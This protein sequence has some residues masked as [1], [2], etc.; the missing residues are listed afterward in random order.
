MRIEVH[1]H[2]ILRDCLPR[3]AKG[4]QATVEVP[5]GATIADLVR[6]MAIDKRLGYDAEDLVTGASWQVM[7]SGKIESDLAREL[8]PGDQVRIL[9][10]VGGG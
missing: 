4:G 1:L 7:V 6:Q 2:S 3:D 9:P 10:P 5:D 8:Q